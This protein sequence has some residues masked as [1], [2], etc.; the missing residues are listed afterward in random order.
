MRVVGDRG[1]AEWELALAREQERVA[2][3]TPFVRS[4]AKKDPSVKR[5]CEGQWSPE[6]LA[7]GRRALLKALLE[8]QP[9]KSEGEGGRGSGSDGFAAARA[10]VKPFL[11][12]KARGELERDSG[13]SK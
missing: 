8:L 7:A 4:V 3:G 10:F 5:E 12:L 1:W 13:K 9:E 6:D 11:E 2:P